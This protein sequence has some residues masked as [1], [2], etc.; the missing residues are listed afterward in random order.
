MFRAPSGEGWARGQTVVCAPFSSGPSATGHAICC[1]THT[2]PPR[3]THTTTNV[4]G[5]GPLKIT[6]TFAAIAVDHGRRI[7]T[8]PGRITPQKNEFAG[9][10]R[11]GVGVGILPERQ[12]HSCSCTGIEYP[13]IAWHTDTPDAPRREESWQWSHPS[14]SGFFVGQR[15]FAGPF[16]FSLH[17]TTTCHH[18]HGQ[19]GFVLAAGVGGASSVASIV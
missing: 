17:H 12:S 8:K 1:R 2:A 18:L 16:G 11:I 10:Y 9:P 19:L 7:R 4:W 6:I 15:S 13:R 14:G 3:H 5:G